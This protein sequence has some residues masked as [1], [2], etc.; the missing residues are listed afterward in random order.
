LDPWLLHLDRADAGEDGPLGQRAV[1]N[2]LLPPVFITEVGAF[3]QV[4]SNLG[5]DG[6][7]Q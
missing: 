3:L 2:D 6:L 7:S 1:A 4:G 5:L